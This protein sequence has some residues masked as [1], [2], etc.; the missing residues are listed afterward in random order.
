M[1]IDVWFSCSQEVEVRSVE[2]EDLFGWHVVW[3]DLVLRF[4]CRVG[5]GVFSSWKLVQEVGE[6]LLFDDE[7]SWTEE[8]KISCILISRC[9]VF[10]YLP[11]VWFVIAK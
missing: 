4:S 3:K 10:V 9:Y 8:S 11:F 5:C 6:L 7:K 1:A 2:E